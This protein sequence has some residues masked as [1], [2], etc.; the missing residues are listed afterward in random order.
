MALPL[1]KSFNHKVL[2]EKLIVLTV[3]IGTVVSGILH[4]LDRINGTSISVIII[5]TTKI[6]MIYDTLESLPS[7]SS[8]VA[9]H[10]YTPNS[11]KH[12]KII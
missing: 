4:Q 12:Q 10:P 11:R 7:E 6:L 2:Q 3:T 1:W 8:V 5:K 9:E